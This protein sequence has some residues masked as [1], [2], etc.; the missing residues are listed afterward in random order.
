MDVDFPPSDKTHLGRAVAKIFDRLS[1]SNA[2]AFLLDADAERFDLAQLVVL[3]AE[4]N[5]IPI[6]HLIPA[7]GVIDETH[8]LAIGVYRGAGS[9]LEVRQAVEGSDCLICVGTRLTDVATGL[10]T[11]QLKSE[12]IIEVHPFGLKVGNEYFSAVSAE[13]LLSE[14][15]KRSHRTRL[16]S[17]TRHPRSTVHREQSTDQAFTQVAFWQR[18][19]KFLRPGDVLIT[20]TGTSFFASSN[21]RLPEGV[22]FIGQPI[23]GSLGYALPAALGTCL[24]LPQRRHLVFLGD[25]AL[26]MTAQELS[27]ILRRDLAPI[28]FLLNNDGYTME[29]L[30]YGADSSYNDLSP[31]LYGRLAAALDPSERIVIHRV[32]DEAQLEQALQATS[33]SIK[34]HLIEVVLPRMDAAEPLVLFAKQAARF[35]FPQLVDVEA[36]RAV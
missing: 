13:G 8:P 26:Q 11:H 10:F 5:G 34:P 4:A 25:G 1:E 17:A 2:P 16:F 30:I 32:R 33:E 12:S 24:A 3:L 27:T 20:D 21:L 15:V 29:R 7:K 31:W 19:E 35:D 18:I 28:I 23:W 14:L 36:G 9:S 22:A 6:A